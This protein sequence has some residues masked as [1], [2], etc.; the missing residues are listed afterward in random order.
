[1][2]ST[3]FLEELNS[4]GFPTT[5][6]EELNSLGFPM[7]ADWIKEGEINGLQEALTHLEENKYMMDDE[8]DEKAFERAH[9]I[10]EKIFS[11][12]SFH[13]N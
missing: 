10:V 8:E 12:K 2:V 3:T 9:E 13:K 4:L 6:L 1:M 7:L 11:P 5:F